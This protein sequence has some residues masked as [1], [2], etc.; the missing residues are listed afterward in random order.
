MNSSERE[1]FAKSVS[2]MSYEELGFRDALAD[3]PPAAVSILFD[4]QGR[5]RT[6]SPALDDLIRFELGISEGADGNTVTIPTGGRRPADIAGLDPD[7][8]LARVTYPASDRWEGA[9]AAGRRAVAH[10]LLGAARTMLEQARQHAL[11]RVQFGQPIAAFQAVRHKLA[12][13][14]VYLEAA[15]A[16]LDGAWDDGGVE[17]ASMAKAFAG[18]SARLAAKHCQQVLAG[19][20]FTTE[21]PFHLYL[22]R[23]LVLDQVLGSGQTLTRDL[24]RR[25]AATKTLPPLLPLGRGAGVSSWGVHPN[26]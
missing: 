16:L 12:D 18:R 20:G 8:E 17:L 10:E 4:M 6:T 24:G 13:T 22:R 2:G 3:D 25:I 11:A 15:D 5:N 14:Y 9:L 21:H 7:L 23:V 1:L 26:Y 19:I